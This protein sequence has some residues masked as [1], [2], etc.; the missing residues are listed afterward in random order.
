MGKIGKAYRKFANFVIITE[1]VLILVFF[2]H[3]YCVKYIKSTKQRSLETILKGNFIR[4]KRNRYSKTLTKRFGGNSFSN[5]DYHP[6]QG[7]EE[8]KEDNLDSTDSF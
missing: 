3:K 2:I 4:K 1:V 8:R 7:E 5:N 6:L